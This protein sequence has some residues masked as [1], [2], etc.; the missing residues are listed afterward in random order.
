MDGLRRLPVVWRARLAASRHQ[1]LSVLLVVVGF[2]GAL[3]GGSLVGT[4]MLGLVMMAESGLLVVWGLARDDGAPVPGRSGWRRS[5]PE[6]LR[7]EAGRP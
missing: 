1:L 2:A 5:V 7:D 6:V 4:W 3:G